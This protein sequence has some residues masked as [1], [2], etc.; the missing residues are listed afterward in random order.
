LKNRVNAVK[1]S[2]TAL[3]LLSEG[4]SASFEE[5]SSI[6]RRVVR[7]QG[8]VVRKEKQLLLV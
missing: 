6:L 7:M 3:F 4:L 2:E 5:G 1:L 8:M